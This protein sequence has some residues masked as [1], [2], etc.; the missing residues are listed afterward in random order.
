MGHSFLK[1]LFIGSIV[2][3]ITALLTTPRSGKEN[4]DILL[5]YVDDTT[6]LVDDVST[7]VNALKDAIQTL[8]T[9]GLELVNEF[10]EDMTDTVEEFTMQNQPRLRR[11]E[12][13]A[14]KLTTD[15]EEIA[16]IFPEIAEESNQ[17]IQVQNT[18]S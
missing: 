17:N 4:R 10:S 14:Q 3:G 16:E 9:E 1:G 13:K 8:T 2:G 15:L 5:S 18:P 6:V 7:S 11:I 12:E